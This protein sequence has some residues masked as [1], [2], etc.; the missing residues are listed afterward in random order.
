MTAP[1][2]EVL[3]VAGKSVA[4]QPDCKMEIRFSGDVVECR[5]W[6]GGHFGLRGTWCD[7]VEAT[8]KN[9]L[10]TFREII[11]AT[12]EAYSRQEQ[13]RLDLAKK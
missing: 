1:A 12:R 13:R 5:R 11:L 4:G 9:A 3:T 10:A 8:E 7:W 6:H 2:W